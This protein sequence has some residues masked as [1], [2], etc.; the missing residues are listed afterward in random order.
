M[1]FYHKIFIIIA[2]LIAASIVN[3]LLF[4]P[5]LS[6]GGN[7][8]DYNREQNINEQITK[9]IFDAEVIKLQSN[10]EKEFNLVININNSSQDSI[11]LL[12]GR[13][14][15]PTEPLVIEPLRQKLL[16]AFNTF[17]LQLPVL[18]KG[19]TFYDY[20]NIF[21][22]SNE[23]INSAIKYMLKSNGK[24]IIIAHSCGT[25]MLSSFIRKYNP[26]SLKA[27][28]LISAGAVDK[29]QVPDK[30]LDYSL[31]NI[32]ILNIYSEYDYSSVMEHANYFTKNLGV[33][34]KN[35]MIPEVDH[36]YRDNSDLLAHEVNKWLK[37]L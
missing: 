5:L 24:I 6:F 1:N 15:H 8:P 32:P 23:R 11:L 9:Y 22:Y 10:I 12:H 35:I 31:L 29:G 20:K 37:S 3:F 18:K 7:L 30:Y 19:K 16:L 17:S 34:F 4:F 14:L 2:S 21:K 33:K 27:I 28:I 25:H 26:D 13:G 36:Y